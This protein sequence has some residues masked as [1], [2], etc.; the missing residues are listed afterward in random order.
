MQEVVARFDRVLTRGCEGPNE[1]IFL[2]GCTQWNAFNA[3]AFAS[4]KT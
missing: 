1:S 4:S 2:W 3:A